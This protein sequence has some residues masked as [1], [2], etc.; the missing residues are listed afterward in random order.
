MAFIPVNF[1]DAQEAKPVPNGRYQLQITDAKEVQSGPNSKRPGSP[2]LRFSI[3]FPDEPN[4]PNITEFRSLP[5][6]DDD[7]SSA[8]FK[9]L[10]LKRFLVHFGIPF[11]STGIDTERLCMEAVGASAMTEVKLDEPDNQGNV[12]NRM[13]IPRL[14]DEP[15]RR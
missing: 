8:N 10:L 2:Q 14:R 7:A 11:D 12:Y 6:E 13:V 3:G 15:G 4:T 5:H 9:A 1:D